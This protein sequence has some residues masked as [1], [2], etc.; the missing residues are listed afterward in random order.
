VLGFTKRAGFPEVLSPALK[1]YVARLQER[2]A[3]R[4]ALERTSQLP[5]S[6]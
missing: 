5:A 1:D 4:A 3:Y 2:P 6:S